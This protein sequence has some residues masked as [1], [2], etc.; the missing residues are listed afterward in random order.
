MFFNAF[1][2]RCEIGE[3]YGCRSFFGLDLYCNQNF[4]WY[5]RVRG[6]NY[7]FHEFDKKDNLNNIIGGHNCELVDVDADGYEDLIVGGVDVKDMTQRF[8]WY[9]YMVL[10]GE[11]K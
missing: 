11:V 9:E 7:I 2:K 5:E 1:G 10:K 3:N 4:G 6:N 8:R